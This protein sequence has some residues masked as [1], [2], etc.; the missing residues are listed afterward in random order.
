MRLLPLV[1]APLVALLALGV[2]ILADPAIAV[3]QGGARYASLQ[4][5]QLADA[6]WSA[7]SAAIVRASLAWMAALQY[8]DSAALDTLM[9]EEYALGAPGEA[10]TPVS[11]ARWIAN[12][13]T[14]VETDTAGYPVLQVRRLGPDVALA[15][16]HLYWRSRVRGRPVPRHYAITDVWVRRGG[17]WRVAARQGSLTTSFVAWTGAIAGA[18]VVGLAWLVSAVLRRRR[19][20]RRRRM[21]G[22]TMGAPATAAA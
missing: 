3:A 4:D 8:R 17:Q 2:V 13:M 7:D 5:A 20:R 12:A 10:R 1:R 22:R 6:A 18:A 11:K 14:S 9:A 19:R 15:R 21:S 16:A